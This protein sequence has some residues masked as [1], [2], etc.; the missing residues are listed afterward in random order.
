MKRR[1][2]VWVIGILAAVLL[3][4]LCFAQ[5]EN[6]NLAE[7]AR[8]R[9]KDKQ[10]EPASKKV[11]DNDTLP[12]EERINVVGGAATVAPASLNSDSAPA[13]QD[14]QADQNSSA[15]DDGDKTKVTVDPSVSSDP[16]AA[17]G[18]REQVNAGWRKKIGDQKDTIKLLERELDVL[19]REYRLRAAAM[20]ADV[21]NR[22]RN[23]G[24]WD[25][26]D[27]DYKDKIEAKQKD[28]ERAKQQLT[29][30]QDQGRKAGIPAGVLQ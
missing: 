4:P 20:Y 28:L 30:M 5:E 12:K 13:N 21:G 3:M 16:N 2:H 29:N 11:F 18:D 17:A 7:A 19:Q 14:A 26:E 24:S 9:R 15:K 22:L 23:S 6:V 1:A 25:K 8:A 27:R 10:S